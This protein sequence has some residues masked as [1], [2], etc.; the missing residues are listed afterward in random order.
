MGEWKKERFCEWVCKMMD[1]M[2]P[3][4]PREGRKYACVRENKTQRSEKECDSLSARRAGC[5]KKRR[6]RRK[7][8]RVRERVRDRERGGRGSE[9]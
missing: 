9:E 1:S 8:E 2:E 7:M 4:R 5:K 3:L 6:E